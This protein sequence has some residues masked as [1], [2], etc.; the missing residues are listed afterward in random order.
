MFGLGISKDDLFLGLG[1]RGGLCD[2]ALGACPCA[3]GVLV[4]AL[5]ASVGLL[6]HLAVVALQALLGEEALLVAGLP[7]SGSEHTR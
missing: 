5:A 1:S 2:D 7:S 6:A 3:P 4:V